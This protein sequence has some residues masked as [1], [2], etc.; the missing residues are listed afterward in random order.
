M[1][2]AIVVGAHAAD[3]PVGHVI[4]IEGVQFVPDSLTVHPGDKVTWIN[5]DPFPHTVTS[6]GSFDSHS[7]ASG[8]SWVYIAAQTGTYAYTCTLHPNMRG[9]LHV[10]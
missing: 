3:K 2:A 6:P 10:R 9:M 1:L 7:I 4:V 8:A 5:K